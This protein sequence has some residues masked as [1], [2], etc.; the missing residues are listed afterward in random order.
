MRSFHKLD[1][2]LVSEGKAAVNSRD[3][4]HESR[5]LRLLLEHSRE[6]VHPVVRCG[7]SNH[8]NKDGADSKT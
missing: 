3:L 5:S 6:F 8:G 1:C 4:L 7:L 2:I